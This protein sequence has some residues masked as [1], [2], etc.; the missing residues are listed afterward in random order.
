MDKIQ[1][2]SNMLDKVYE[3]I[4]GGGMAFTFLKVVN[5]G[6]GTSLYDE[7]AKIVKGLM[8]KAEKKMV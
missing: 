7:G 2:I 8:S 5:T 4:L 6:M 3:M 1:L